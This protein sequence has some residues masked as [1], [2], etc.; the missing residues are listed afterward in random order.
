[1]GK[2][3]IISKA[4]SQRIRFDG[5]PSAWKLP[6]EFKGLQN[7][8]KKP[9]AIERLKRILDAVGVLRPFLF[10]VALDTLKSLKAS[11]TINFSFFYTV[12]SEGTLNKASK[13]EYEKF[14]TAIRE[15]LIHLD[16]NQISAYAESFARIMMDNQIIFTKCLLYALDDT[17]VLYLR[18]RW[19]N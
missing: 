8:I 9:A 3:N 17:S 19:F 4:K 15:E 6:E 5:M 16:E 11:T 10:C 12:M 14:L 2:K 18:P 13:E 1:V 7:L